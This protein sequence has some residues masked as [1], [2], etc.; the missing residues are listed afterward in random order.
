M[1]PGSQQP[2]DPGA[3]RL[4]LHARLPGRAVLAR[5]PPEHDPRGHAR[6]PGARPAGP[7]GGDGRR[8]GLQLLAARDQRDDRARRSQ[9]RA[10]AEHANALAGALQQ[11]GAATKAAWATGDPDEAL[12]NATPYLQAFGHMVIAWIW[13]DVALC[14]H[15]RARCGQRPTRT[16]CRRG[17]LRRA[18]CATS[19]TTSCRR[20]AP[21]CSGGREH[22]RRRPARRHGREA[23][24]SDRASRRP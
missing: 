13:L 18:T 17:R 10:L 16:S 12:A 22:A 21:G 5:Q 3:R 9:R 14:A 7:Q 15:A 11:L 4:R 19:S 23:V 6:H 20:S 8:P 24:R 2:G 1:V